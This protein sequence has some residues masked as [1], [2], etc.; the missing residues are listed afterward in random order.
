MSV[1]TTRKTVTFS[2]PFRLPEV[3]RALPAGG[4][5]VVTEEE[6]IEEL[7][8]PV[9]R[10]ISTAILL[11]VPS[12]SGPTIEMVTVDAAGLLEAMRRDKAMTSQPAN[13]CAQ[14]R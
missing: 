13:G 4:Y 3:D 12:A 7:S 8:F 1:R 14:P 2:N 11:P 10:R 9:Y 5:E 6:L